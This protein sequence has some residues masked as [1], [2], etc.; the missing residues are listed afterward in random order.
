MMFFPSFLD[1]LAR[2]VSMKKGKNTCSTED[3]I[4]REVAETLAKDAKKNDLMLSS[5]ATFKSN[6][7]NN[8]ASICS[9][10]G[11]KGIN[12]DCTIV[13]EVF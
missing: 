6:K 12:Q 8:F 9:K 1:G 7:S 13:W 11:Q 5:S 4:G 3:D 2:T 10:R